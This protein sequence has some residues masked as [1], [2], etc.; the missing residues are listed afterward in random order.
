[1]TADYTNLANPMEYGGKDQV[2]ISN[3]DKLKITSIGNSTLMNGC[4]MLSLDNVLYVPC[5]KFSQCI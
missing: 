1:M 3:G 4:Y 5:Q 2:T